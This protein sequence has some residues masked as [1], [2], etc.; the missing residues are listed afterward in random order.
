MSQTS[1]NY[2]SPD[3]PGLRTYERDSCVVFHK[4]REDF[5]GLSNMATGYPLQVAGIRIPTSEALYQACR[6]PHLPEIQELII[7]Q[8]SPMTAKMK[9]KPHRKDTRDDWDTVRVGVMKWCLKVKLIQHWEPFSE[10]LLSTASKPIV[11]LSRRDNFW[12]AIPDSNAK[13]LIGSNVLGRLLMDIRERLKRNSDEF[14]VLSP[15]PISDFV[16]LGHPIGSIERE[17]THFSE[18]HSSQKRLHLG[19]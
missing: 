7:R 8:A 10:L 19:R 1:E 11:E 3:I 6:F 12:G 18:S 16:I 9:S 17:T 2:P 14:S 5:G 15:L 13:S 4:T